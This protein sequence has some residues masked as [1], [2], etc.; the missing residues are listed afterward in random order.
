MAET[1]TTDDRE[2]AGVVGAGVSCATASSLYPQC[3]QKA[4]PGSSGAPH[5]G[6]LSAAPASNAR[7]VA[8]TRKNTITVVLAPARMSVDRRSQQVGEKV[9]VN[10]ALL[11]AVGTFHIEFQHVQR[12]GLA[13]RGSPA[14]LSEDLGVPGPDDVVEGPDPSQRLAV[15][16]A[17]N[18]PILE[19]LVLT[20]SAS[21]QMADAEAL[22]GGR[23]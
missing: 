4:A 14:C 16:T 20:A 6:Q 23:P 19:A 17:D 5:F 18:V 7:A 12:N 8:S 1:F 9:G 13:V 11:P 21:E 15:D 3:V 22:V 2:S 10:A